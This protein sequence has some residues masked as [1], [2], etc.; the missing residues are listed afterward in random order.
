[1]DSGT[2]SGVTTDH[3][4]RMK[5]IERENRELV[6]PELLILRM[7]PLGVAL[8]MWRLSRMFS[9]ATSLAGECLNQ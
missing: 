6:R 7:W 3:A 8:F 9:H 4:Q 5:E 2:K 1:M